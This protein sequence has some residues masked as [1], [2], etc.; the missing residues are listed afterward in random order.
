MPIASM[1]ASFALQQSPAVPSRPSLVV[2]I[3]SDPIAGNGLP[4]MKQ[5]FDLAA[6]CASLSERRCPARLLGFTKLDLRSTSSR[7]IVTFPQ[8]VS[9]SHKLGAGFSMS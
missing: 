9:E 8:P 2:P 1:A 7:S 5:E 3:K 4:Q 6:A